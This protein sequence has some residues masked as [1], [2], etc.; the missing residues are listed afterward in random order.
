MYKPPSLFLYNSP[1]TASF[2]PTLGQRLFSV[3]VILISC[4]AIVVIILVSCLYGVASYSQTKI[5]DELSDRLLFNVIMRVPDLANTIFEFPYVMVRNMNYLVDVSVNTTYEEMRVALYKTWLQSDSVFVTIYYVGKV[6]AGYYAPYGTNLL[7]EIQ[8]QNSQLVLCPVYDLETGKGDVDR[9]IPV[10]G[11]DLAYLNPFFTELREATD[12]Q[13]HWSQIH[14][15]PRLNDTLSFTCG[16]H[17]YD[18]MTSSTVGFFAADLTTISLQNSLKTLEISK[19]A[20]VWVMQPDGALIASV[21]PLISGNIIYG[22]NSSSEI[23]RHT[24]RLLLT[25]GLVD[26]EYYFSFIMHGQKIRAYSCPMKEFNLDLY[27]I[28]AFPESDFFESTYKLKT[29]ILSVGAGVF[30]FSVIIGIVI[31]YIITK[32]LQTLGFQMNE[33]SRG[34]FESTNSSLATNTKIHE[35]RSLQMDFQRMVNALRSFSKFVPGDVVR[36]YLKSNME[37]TTHMSQREVSVMFSDI[38]NFTTKVEEMSQAQLTLVLSDYLSAMCAVID[39]EKGTIDKFIGD[40]V[41]ALWNVPARQED[42]PVLACRAALESLKSL[43]IL[44][45]KWLSIGLTIVECRIGIHTGKALVGTLGSK[46]RLAFTA[47]GDTIN[48]GARLESLNKKYNT[49]ILISGDVYQYVKD[50]FLCRF[51]DVVVVCGKT[52]PTAVYELMDYKIESSAKSQQIAS[53]QGDALSLFLDKK[54]ESSLSI[55]EWLANEL[56]NDACVR[57][58]RERVLQAQKNADS[59]P[60]DWTGYLILEDK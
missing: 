57:L 50:T 59:L 51:L 48:L 34:S 29:I 38:K 14:K 54:F 13:P 33:I 53:A 25:R 40:A 12:L 56:P 8:V 45:E 32:P 36:Y 47:V 15:D 6:L 30:V 27:V 37:A 58:L 9:P 39:T 44:N 3:R 23:V 52:T 4:F 49:T 18:K 2:R 35:L 16:L 19:N 28:V 41:M 60:P 43:A 31:I 26:E 55:Y 11:Y 5:T 21:P 1:D 10:A 42:H 24:T 46:E 20:F 22:Q 17:V 7:Y